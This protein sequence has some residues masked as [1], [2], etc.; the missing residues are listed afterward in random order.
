MMI[1]LKERDEVL[2][3]NMERNK[4]IIHP[5]TNFAWRHDLVNIYECMMMDILYQFYKGLV[6]DM[7]DL[8]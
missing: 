4:I 2:T 6:S 5:I 7:M 1:K 3:W 8:I